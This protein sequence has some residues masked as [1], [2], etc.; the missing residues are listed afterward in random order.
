MSLHRLFSVFLLLGFIACDNEVKVKDS[1]GDGFADPGE[2]C[3]GADLAGQSCESLGHYNPG[4]TLVCRPDCTWDRA[5]CGGRCGDDALDTGNGETCDGNEFGG[6]TCTTIGYHGGYLQCTADC[7]LDTTVCEESGACGDGVIQPNYG[8]VCDTDDLAGETCASL[9]FTEGTLACSDACAYDLS[10]CVSGCG[11]G[12]VEVGETCDDGNP[13]SGDGCDADCAVEEGWECDD[14]E[15]SGCAPI[16]GDGLIV[17]EET[18][19]GADLG[20]ATCGSLGFPGG[21][22]AC[23][24]DCRLDTTGC[25]AWVAVDVGLAHTC[26]IDGDGALWCWGDNEYGQLGT[27]NTTDSRVPVR[28]S[29]LTADVVAV[30]AGNR[31]TCAL[32]TADKVWC[33]GD[34]SYGQLGIGSTTD[35][36]TPTAIAT[37]LFSSISVGTNFTCGV[38][39]DQRVACWGINAN[40]QCGFSGNNPHEPRIF[41][42]NSVTG[43]YCG[44]LHVHATTGDG[45]YGWGYD[46]AGQLGDGATTNPVPHTIPFPSALPSGGDLHTCFLN[47]SGGVH[48]T[49]DNQ[50]CQL[51][52]GGAC[53]GMLTSPQVVS[54]LV[55]GVLFLDAGGNSNCVVKT[56]GSVHCWG[57]ADRHQLGNGSTNSKPGPEPVT[58]LTGGFAEVRV[59]RSHGCARA[60]EGYL[61]C[62]GRNEAGQV[63]DGT[64]DVR[65]TPV[66]VTVTP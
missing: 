53:S 39:T 20:G 51:G 28:V 65:P 27:G 4:G 25:E 6:E 37:P 59:N 66:R 35:K 14:L 30:A 23:G 34:N 8:E 49:G 58:G 3:D 21:A 50:N 32:T 52:I 55:S 36:T 26:A 56:G 47:G 57:Q 45:L 17:G 1:C 63:G 24:A 10:G 19:E 46:V 5:D 12:L 9:G 11:N 62:W 48:C 2:E 7:T 38:L 31:H 43:V 61:V 22:L 15:P 18:C 60:T 42:L 54:G 13:G 44:G 64:L 29:G 16:C 40:Q 41:S 33:W